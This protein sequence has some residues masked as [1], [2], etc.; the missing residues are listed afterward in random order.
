MV[1]YFHHFTDG[2]TQLLASV[3]Q[4]NSAVQDSFLG[5]MLRSNDFEVLC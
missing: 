3:G 5:K 4:W 1:G 2:G